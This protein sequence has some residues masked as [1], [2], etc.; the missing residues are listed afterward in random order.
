MPD[1]T[2]PEPGARTSR[3]PIVAAFIIVIIAVAFVAVLPLLSA[4]V[5]PPPA[6]RVPY[7][8]T[9]IKLQ[10]QKVAPHRAQGPK[11]APSPK[12]PKIRTTRF[13]GA[14]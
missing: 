4:E 5:P 2:L 14:L 13:A 12:I 7:A 11:T 8:P 6:L 1:K 9:P 10:P 3:W